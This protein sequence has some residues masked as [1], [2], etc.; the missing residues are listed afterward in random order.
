MKG[1]ITRT[2]SGIVYVA[3]IVCGL[4]LGPQV[5]IAFLE[6]LAL[7]ALA[8]FYGLVNQGRERP[9]T[10]VW[11]LVGGF[12][13]VLGLYLWAQGAPAAPLFG[14]LYIIYIVVRLTMQLY[15]REARAIDNLA[16]S[17]MGQMYI[18]LPIGLM[19]FTYFH[20]AGGGA[21]LLAMFIMIWL[22]DTG[23]FCV[24]SLIGKHKMFPRVSPK[25]SWEGL[26]GGIVF[27]VCS[28]FI[29]KYCFSQSYSELALWQ[30][31]LMGAVVGVF[32]TWGDLVESLLK[33]TLGVKDS[34]KMIPGHGG[35]LDRIDS[36][37][38]VSPALV[39]YLFFIV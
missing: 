17:L 23:A 14:I 9:V 7:L 8:E 1:L 18:A 12:T 4:L 3:V 10:L 26:V 36:L 27:A 16:Y 38:L 29:F 32:A 25:K 28:A 39:I 21:L 15:T 5:F 37:L 2:L 6:L 13:A 11:D 22:N 35:I 30:M 31:L 19:A 24:G 33:R 34:G 20:G